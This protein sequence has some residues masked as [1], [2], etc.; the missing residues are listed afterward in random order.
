M[1]PDRANHPNRPLQKWLITETQ[2]AILYFALLGGALVFLRTYVNPK[3]AVL[4]LLLLVALTY[5]PYLK[6]FLREI[7]AGK[8]S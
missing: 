3:A 7:I 5:F 2:A 4:Y 6:K 8:T 1:D